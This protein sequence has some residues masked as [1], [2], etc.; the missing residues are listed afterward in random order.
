MSDRRNTPSFV[1]LV[2][3]CFAFA[4]ILAVVALLHPLPWI[5]VPVGLALIAGVIGLVAVATRARR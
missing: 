4:V 5:W 1:G 2:V 3:S